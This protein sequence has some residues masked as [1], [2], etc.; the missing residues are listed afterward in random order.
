MAEVA[1][2]ELRYRFDVYPRSNGLSECAVCDEFV[3]QM[4]YFLRRYGFGQVE[5]GYNEVSGGADGPAV[6]LFGGG[7]CFWFS[8]E[9]KGAIKP[10]KFVIAMGPLCYG[11][12]GRQLRRIGERIPPIKGL[13]ESSELNRIYD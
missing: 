2:E 7:D 5:L 10:G 6:N 8:V 1:L 11:S 12:F 13:L 3:Y 9:G 4:F